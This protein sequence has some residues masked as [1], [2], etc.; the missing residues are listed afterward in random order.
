[1]QLLL[2]S[3]GLRTPERVTFFA[4]QLRALCGATRRILFVPWAL[5]DHDGYLGMMHERGLD[6]GYELQG[7]HRCQD[8]VRAVGE[9]EAILIGGG[10]TFRLTHALQ[11][12]G[13]VEV[14]RARVRAGLP[15][16]GI[17]A[18][19]NVACPTLCTSN[20]M[21]IVEP[22]SFETLGL[23]PFQIN[24]HYYS[25]S[26]YVRTADS[27]REH[28][29]ETRD[30]R[31]AEFHEEKAVPVL[32]LAEGAAVRVREAS[33]E[34]IGGPARLFRRGLAPL[35]LEPPARLDSHL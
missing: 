35:D 12:H 21:P 22:E 2:S 13:L 28:F 18:G 15:Y 32:G 1:M 26:N 34:L 5:A 6:A 11:R 8:P 17:S 19:T 3:G 29:G 30:Q 20:D 24:P 14:L 25:G 9:A 31:I 16:A 4:A 10:N 33:I 7:I 27:Y 23:V